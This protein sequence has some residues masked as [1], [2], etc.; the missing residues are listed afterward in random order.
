MYKRQLPGTGFETLPSLEIPT[1]LLKFLKSLSLNSVGLGLECVPF[2]SGWELVE[3]RPKLSKLELHVVE[4]LEICDEVAIEDSSKAFGP[5]IE[6]G[7][8]EGSSIHDSGEPPVE[9]AGVAPTMVFEEE[10][11]SS[12]EI[13]KARA[14]VEKKKRD[15]A[16]R[17]V[18]KTVHDTVEQGTGAGLLRMDVNEVRT[19]VEP[20]FETVE[21]EMGK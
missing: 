1:N 10:E 13:P 16:L 18:D 11:E 14:S 2:H 12:I 7:L 5:L 3:W 9:A 19:W 20:I 15:Q 21:K 8:G 6:L 4:I 17:A